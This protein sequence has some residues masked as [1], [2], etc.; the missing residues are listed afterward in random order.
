[1]NNQKIIKN[2]FFGG[3]KKED[4]INYIEQLQREIAEL[5]KSQAELCCLKND[6]N[7]LEEKLARYEG[8]ADDYA[9]QISSLKED[10]LKLKDEIDELNIINS[11][12]CAVIEEYERKLVTTEAKIG[13]LEH[14]ISEMKESYSRVDEAEKFI[15]DIKDDAR[16]SLTG[17][18]KD[19][20]ASQE[21]IK[22]AS[23]NFESALASIKSS[24]EILVNVLDIASDRLGIVASEEQV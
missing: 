21:R 7:A 15:S 19:V 9:R 10:K 12:N 8:S 23:V 1:M 11:D 16:N 6:Y 17:V 3:F 14:T 2:T 13:L 18:K 24:T 20:S 5:K 22:T 4:V